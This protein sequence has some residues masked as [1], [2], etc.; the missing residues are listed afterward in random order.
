MQ[1]RLRTLTEERD[2]LVWSS[3]SREA[4]DRWF[5][6]SY[7]VYLSFLSTSVTHQEQTT[8]SQKTDK[9]FEKWFDWSSL[10][11]NT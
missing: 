4:I 6:I 11:L 7:S 1:E 3:N 8:K 2:D 9:N 5:P 10:N